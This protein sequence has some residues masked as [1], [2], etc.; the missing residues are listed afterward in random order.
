[1]GEAVEILR[2]LGA[3]EHV[4]AGEERPLRAIET[5]ERWVRGEDGVTLADVRS[6]NAAAYAAAATAARAETLGR[7]A[8]LVRAR[9]P[10]AA[11]RRALR[12]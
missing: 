5:A 2:R 1:M 6:A 8:D 4:P 3:C 9:I 11:V 7:C 10:W 12:G